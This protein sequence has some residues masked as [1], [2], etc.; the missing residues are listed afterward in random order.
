[1]RRTLA[2]ALFCFLVA[3]LVTGCATPQTDRL[4]QAPVA[5]QGAI[6][7]PVF[8]AQRTKECGPAALAMTLNHAGVA[9]TPDTLVDEVYTPGR[10]GSLTSALVAATRRHGRIAY[11]VNDLAAIL[12]AID[13]G[14]PV[15]VLQNL[16]LQWLPRWHY[17]VAVGYDLAAGTITLHSGTSPFHTLPLTTFERTWARGDYWALVTLPPDVFPDP[18]HEA[19]YLRAVAGVERAGHLEV[20]ARAYA[21]ALARWPQ[22]AVALMGHGNTLY[23]LGHKEEAAAAFRLAATRLPDN[24]DAFNNLGHVLAELGQLEAAADAARAA[25]QLGGPHRAIYLETLRSIE[26]RNTPATG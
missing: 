11:P 17:A 20:A 4:L 9:V 22:N 7:D 25:V 14:Q 24:A 8:F 12:S 23:G 19:T 26:A 6:T 15:L 5:R 10:E 18:A 16:G 1:M 13:N 21:K 2:A 3:G